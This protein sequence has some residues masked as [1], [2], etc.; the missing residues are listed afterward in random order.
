MAG[1]MLE[2]LVFSSTKRSN[3]AKNIWF[4]V[5]TG[6]VVGNFWW[7][8]DLALGIYGPVNNHT[9]WMWRPSWNVRA[10]VSIADPA[11]L[12]LGDERDVR[13]HT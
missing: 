2:L 7:F 4:I 6:L 12:Q 1:H 10:S 3:L 11:D 5:L 13:T 9:G 8:K